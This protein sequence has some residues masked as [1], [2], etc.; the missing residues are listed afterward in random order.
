MNWSS[1]NKKTIVGLLIFLFSLTGAVLRFLALN[2]TA[3]ANGWDGY[4]YVMQ[5]HSWIEYGHLQS[6]DY[7]LV[8]PFYT[9][10]AYL[11]PDYEL[12]FKIGSAIISGLLLMSVSLLVYQVHKQVVPVLIILSFLCFSPLLTYFVVQFPKNVLGLSFF[13]GFLLMLQRKRTLGITFFF[14]L[15]IMTHR[16]MAGFALIVL[17]GYGLQ[18]LPK[19]WLLA[20]LVMAALLSLLPGIFHWTDLERLDGMFSIW[21]QFAPWSFYRLF[22]SSWSRWWGIELV[23]IVVMLGFTFYWYVKNKLWQHDN[24]VIQWVFPLL[25]LLSLCPFMI[26]MNGSLGYRFFMVVPVFLVIY[27]VLIST[28]EHG[29]L[30]VAMSFGFLIMSLFSFRSYNPKLHD[31]PNQVYEL[32]TNRIVAAYD[33]EQYPLIVAHKSL[34]EMIIYQTDFDALNWKP[35]KS[36]SQKALRITNGLAY[37]HFS[38]YLSEQEL[39]ELIK[40]TTNY[41]SLPESLWLHFLERVKESADTEMINRIKRYQNPMEVLPA[42]L[43]KSKPQP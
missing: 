24:I 30:M 36:K 18:F 23:L 34:A 7:S 20:T 37:Y 27:V 35:D 9:S 40:L 2:Q 26:F 22:Q 14:V 19:R 5:A 39:N 11:I 17:L 4:Y 29:K 41:Y 43:S 42:F 31:P 32:I 38:K 3:Y 12:S 33:P 13:I 21:P 8:Y 10:I 25:I 6:L 15:T 16:M 28:V 1:W